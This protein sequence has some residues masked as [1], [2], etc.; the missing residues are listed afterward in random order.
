MRAEEGDESVKELADEAGQA[1]EELKES[2][3]TGKKV[4]QEQEKSD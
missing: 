2:T 3:D 4:Q 1:K